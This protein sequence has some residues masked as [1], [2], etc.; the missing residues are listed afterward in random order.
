[1]DLPLLNNGEMSVEDALRAVRRSP[2]QNPII[3]ALI[4]ALSGSCCV[5]V[6]AAIRHSPIKD[7]FIAVLC[8]GLIIGSI[9]G[10]VGMLL[11]YHDA[12]ILIKYDALLQGAAYFAAPAIGIAVVNM[13]LNYT[14]LL[15]DSLVGACIIFGGACIVIVL[16][17][18]A[19]LHNEKFP[20]LF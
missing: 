11:V 19:Q 7:E 1:M 13:E 2:V 6:G 15:I 3:G 16:G 17:L 9:A 5:A 14:T 10:T 20:S 18:V 4:C 12:R 8:G